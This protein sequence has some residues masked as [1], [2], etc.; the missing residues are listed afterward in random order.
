MQAT[1]QLGWLENWLGRAVGD[2]LSC[3]LAIDQPAGMSNAWLETLNGWGVT[4]Q[5]DEQRRQ[6]AAATRLVR[7]APVDE[8]YEVLELIVRRGRAYFDQIRCPDD[9]VGMRRHERLQRRLADVR[10]QAVAFYRKHVIPPPKSMFANAMAAAQDGNN[11]WAVREQPVIL[12][13][14]GCGAP[15]MDDRH[16]E[17]EFCGG[18][19]GHTD[20]RQNN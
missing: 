12:R 7:G 5:T 8:L 4:P 10:D 1:E 11:Q 17:C 6:T 14:V 9:S 15:R 3:A 16:F 13:C 2:A 19:L 20:W 18:H